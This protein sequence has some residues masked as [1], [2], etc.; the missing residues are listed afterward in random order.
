MSSLIIQ[1]LKRTRKRRQ[2][3]EEGDEGEEDERGGK[4][5]HPNCLHKGN[6]SKRDR[7]HTGK[8]IQQSDS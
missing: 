7:N 8:I 6:V 5:E 1:P 2:E 4:L 3:K